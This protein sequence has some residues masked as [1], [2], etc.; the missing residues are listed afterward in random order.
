[1]K[2]IQYNRIKAA[3]ADKKVTN[4]K[5]AAQLSVEPQ[6]VSRWC[7]N[8]SQPSIEMLYGNI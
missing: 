3:L 8:H 7:T 2:P 6:T 4:K 1:M 5:L